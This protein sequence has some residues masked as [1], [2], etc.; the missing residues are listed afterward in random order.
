[1]SQGLRIN[2]STGGGVVG[3]FTTPVLPG[4]VV[5]SECGEM[6]E[7]IRKEEKKGGGKCGRGRAV[8]N[9]SL[10]GHSLTPATS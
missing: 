10:G 8:G 4:Q 5:N 1:M 7:Y 6:G 9:W 2:N 3:E